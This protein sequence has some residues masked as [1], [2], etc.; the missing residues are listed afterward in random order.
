MS[1]NSVFSITLSQNIYILL[2]LKTELKDVKANIFV[3]KFHNTY[4]DALFLLN[5]QIYVIFKAY[6]M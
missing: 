6:K 4:T 2:T 5:F 1:I 3:Y